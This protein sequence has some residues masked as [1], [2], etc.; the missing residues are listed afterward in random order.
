MARRI[1]PLSDETLAHMDMP[2]ERFDDMVASLKASADQ[3]GGFHDR[4]WLAAHDVPFEDKGF[5]WIP[6]LGAPACQFND[7]GVII[8]EVAKAMRWMGASGDPY[9]VAC[10]FL[11]GHAWLESQAAP[12]TLTHTDP[13]TLIELVRAGILGD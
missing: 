10:W 11:M 8:P 2:R 12:A 5:L 1:Q 13:A 4:E 6:D 7:Q 9:G 3:L